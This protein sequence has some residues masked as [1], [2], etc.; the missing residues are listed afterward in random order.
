MSSNYH[1]IVSAYGDNLDGLADYLED[2][3]EILRDR[4]ATEFNGTSTVFDLGAHPNAIYEA[5]GFR[6]GDFLSG[7][8]Y[9]I[10]Q[11]SADPQ[12]FENTNWTN[13]VED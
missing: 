1:V 2:L 6:K 10:A 4:Q 13:V 9:V 12:H 5:E 7:N 8:V 3:A 11:N